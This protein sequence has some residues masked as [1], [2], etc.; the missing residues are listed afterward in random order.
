[1]RGHSIRV[2]AGAAITVT[3]AA[4]VGC[5]LSVASATA[6]VC[7][8]SAVKEEPRICEGGEGLFLPVGGEEN[9]PKWLQGVVW[10]VLMCYLFLGVALLADAFMAAIEV[11][12][13]KT[14][15]RVVAGQSVM[16]RVWN[17]TVANLSLMALGSSAPEIILS[18]VGLIGND[19]FSES[20]GPSTIVGSASFNLFVIIGICV[21]A[22]P[23]TDFRRIERL[24]VYKVT[25]ANSLFAYIWLLIILGSFG[26]SPDLVEVWEG[27]LTF[28]FFP[29][30][31]I[32][33][34]MSDIGM[35]DSGKTAGKERDIETI[36]PEV[37]Q[38]TLPDTYDHL[39]KISDSRG[40][41]IRDLTP[42]LAADQITADEIGR[43]YFSRAKYRHNAIRELFG[44]KEV[45]P[46][47]VT[48]NHSMEQI[49]LK[50]VVQQDEHSVGFKFVQHIVLENCGSA[51]LII[52][53][54]PDLVDTDVTVWYETIDG[55][56]LAG[57]DYVYAKKK[58]HIPPHEMERTIEIEILD[59]DEEEDDETFTVRLFN[60]HCR[61]PLVQLSPMHHEAHVLI[62]DDDRP[63]KISMGQQS[64]DIQEGHGAAR[65]SLIR[66]GGGKGIISCD[67][68]TKDGSAIAGKDYVEVSGTVTFKDGELEKD[69]HIE[70]VDDEMYEKDE[71][72]TFQLF[73]PRGAS[74]ELGSYTFT[75]VHIRSDDKL[76][77]LVEKVTHL[78]NINYH[79]FQLGQESWWQQIREA[80]VPEE[81]LPVVGLVM[82]FVLLPWALFAATIPPTLY[83]NGWLSFVW[84][85][86]Y[87]GIVTAVIGDV[88]S[89]FGCSIGL[90]DS[91][92]AIT[93]VALGTSLPDTFASR[94]AALNDDTADA[95]IGNVTGSNAVNVYLGLGLPWLIA[96]IYWRVKGPTCEWQERYPGALKDYPNGGFYVEAGPLVFSV[97]VFAALALSTFGVLYGRRVAVGG[98]LGGSMAKLVLLLLVLF[99]A[100]FVVL[101]SLKFENII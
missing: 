3:R 68:S 40:I 24:S 16:V 57:S 78:L 31:L 61:D 50:P 22:I 1:M 60:L 69:I 9:W 83:C 42:Q 43:M 46:D 72:F 51:A 82:H 35:F 29:L 96:S 34:Y 15:V 44:K 90:S 89:L 84:A 49:F 52:T 65:I 67:Y 71:T 85:L 92:T 59:D 19:F 93:F 2:G 11:I 58:V 63:G 37:T 100:V 94:T 77:T 18:L 86:A 54:S 80:V 56:A 26:T 47:V 79:R 4:I 6:P 97:S 101:S 7:N 38:F 36:G 75:E 73:N 20:L 87:I 53:K 48:M 14:H 99:W 91:V 41:K 30:M 8:L 28:L 23:S 66:Q 10:F 74:R 88:A 21:A 64:V 13:S 39:M 33:A 62:I 70:I 81:D 76:T 17:P 27:V 45:I 55:E 32:L 12:T 5:T 95:A 98:E 25:A